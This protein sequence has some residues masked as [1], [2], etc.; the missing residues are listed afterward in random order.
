ME[1]DRAGVRSIPGAA[2]ADPVRTVD[3]FPG[4]TRVS[5]IGAS[6]NV[7]G[8]SADQNLVLL[9]GVPIFNPFHM[10]GIFS[11]FNADMVKRTQLR[12]GG[13]AP[14]YGGRASSVLL[15]ESDL[16]DGKFGVDAGLS[17]L[18]ARLAV[19]GGLPEEVRDTVSAWPPP[20]GGS[21]GAAATPTSWPTRS[22]RPNSPIT[23]GTGSS[24]S[25]PGPGAEAGWGSPIIR[26]RTP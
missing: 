12:S 13:F 21:P 1:T 26:G 22:C 25:R 15:V 5:E 16:G 18:T 4:V 6:F 11:V 8:G 20:G 14:E 10:L 24:A 23:W 3:A 7:R 19:S 9:D 2:E 17:L